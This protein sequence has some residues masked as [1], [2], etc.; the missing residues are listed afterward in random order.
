MPQAS[1]LSRILDEVDTIITQGIQERV[2]PGATL[3]IGWRGETVKCAAYGKTADREYGAYSPVPVTTKTLYDLASLTKIVATTCA[4]MRL[5]EQGLLQLEDPV[6]K[7]IPQFGADPQKSTITIQHML[8]HTSG[9]PGP[10]KLYKQYHGKDQIIDGICSQELVFRPGTQRLYC[11]LGFILLGEVIRVASSLRLDEY[12]QRYLFAPM[13]MR[14]TMFLPP[15][16]LKDRVAP[17]ELVNWRGGLVHGEVHDENAWATGGVAGHAG[18]F[19]TVE[20]L[21]QFCLMIMERGEHEGKRILHTGSVLSME[22][23]QV[24]DPDESSGLG[25]VINAPYFMG[26]LA[27]SNTIGHTGFTGTSMVLDP[28]RRLAVILLTN[29]VCPTRNGPRLNPYRRGIADTVAKLC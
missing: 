19:S 1:Q 7:Y 4:I 26:N 14:D 8:T 2:F 29:C 11:D 9:L 12:A 28:T 24:P 15:E 3:W 21:A 10:L 18:L 6:S 16:T 23:L 5:V 17:T 27:S 13:N 22:T 20:D 25:W